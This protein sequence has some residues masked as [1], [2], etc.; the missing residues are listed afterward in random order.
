M[1]DPFVREKYAEVEQTN[2]VIEGVLVPELGE[3]ASSKSSDQNYV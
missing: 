1:L 2:S 3:P